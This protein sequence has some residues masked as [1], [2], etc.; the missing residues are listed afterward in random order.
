M[1]HYV[2]HCRWIHVDQK[3][4]HAD[5]QGKVWT[6]TANDLLLKKD[7]L[8]H[9]GIPF[10]VRS[11]TVKTLRVA[12]LLAVLSRE[13]LSSLAGLSFR[14]LRRDPRDINSPT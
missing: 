11:G 1:S 3:Q 9:L 4:L 2:H 13:Y 7:C 12:S 6:L 10:T 8:D 14:L 5:T